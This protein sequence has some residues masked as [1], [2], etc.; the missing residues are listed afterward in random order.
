VVGDT[1]VGAG[2]TAAGGARVNALAADA[3]G[4]T[5]TI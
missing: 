2:G 3:G 5:A 1:A 4:V